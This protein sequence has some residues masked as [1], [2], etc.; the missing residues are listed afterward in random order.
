M[1]DQDEVTSLISE[2]N[3][4][5]VEKS[6]WSSNGTDVVVSFPVIAGDKSVFKS[7]LQGVKQLEYVKLAQQIWVEN[8]TN[9]DKC[10]DKNLRLKSYC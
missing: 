9:I 1:N 8:G 2:V 3:P 4:K 7:D 5:M 10:V 6:V